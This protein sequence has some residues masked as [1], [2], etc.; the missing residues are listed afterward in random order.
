[1]VGA[2]SRKE[3]GSCSRRSITCGHAVIGL[4]EGKGGYDLGVISISDAPN[5]AL[6]I[7][8]YGKVPGLEVVQHLLPEVF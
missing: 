2:G 7:L 3:R 8:K 5:T 6:V 1:M 4:S